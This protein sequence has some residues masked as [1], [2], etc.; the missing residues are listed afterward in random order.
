[1][2]AMQM[3]IGEGLK[4]DTKILTKKELYLLLDHLSLSTKWSQLLRE[5]SEGLVNDTCR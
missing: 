1:M 2:H 3:Q 4:P 5:S